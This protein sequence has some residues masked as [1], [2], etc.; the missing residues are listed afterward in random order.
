MIDN[1]GMPP[2]KFKTCL[3]YF[4]FHDCPF[5]SENF[6]FTLVWKFKTKFISLFLTLKQNATQRSVRTLQTETTH[7]TT[8]LSLLCY[9]IIDAKLLFRNFSSN[10][11]S[12]SQNE[13]STIIQ[14][15]FTGVF[16][17]TWTEWLQNTSKTDTQRMDEH[18]RLVAL[19]LWSKAGLRVC[20]P[21]TTNQC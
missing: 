12:I 17:R 13:F 15:H 6:E 14:N 9:I 7:V 8:A 11:R 21:K 10:C 1:Y 4:F 5:G 2:W 3:N 18:I 16:F 20:Q 19:K